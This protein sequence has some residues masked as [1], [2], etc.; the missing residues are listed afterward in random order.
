MQGPEDSAHICAGFLR[1]IIT[2]NSIS[3]VRAVFYNSAPDPSA[4]ETDECRTSRTG[5]IA[6]R[7]TLSIKCDVSLQQ[8]ILKIKINI[9]KKGKYIDQSRVSNIPGVNGVLQHVEPLAA[10][11]LRMLYQCSRCCHVVAEITRRPARLRRNR[12]GVDQV[13]S[14]KIITRSTTISYLIPLVVH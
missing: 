13:F 1:N 10:Q 14:G 6:P 12:S 3:S 4:L 8:I 9:T 5:F 2:L 11:S 7:S